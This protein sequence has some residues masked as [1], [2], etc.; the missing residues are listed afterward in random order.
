MIR[1][2]PSETAGSTSFA[3]ILE[4]W[5]SDGYAGAWAWHYN[6]APGSTLVRDFKTAKGCPAGF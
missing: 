6:E 2:V 5:W 4:S 3:Q 1:V